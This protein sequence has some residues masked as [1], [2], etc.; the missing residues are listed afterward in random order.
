VKVPADN[1]P[2]LKPGTEWR[3]KTFG[4]AIRSRVMVFEPHRELGWDAH[5]LANHCYHGWLFEALDGG[6][7]T[8][9]VT[10]ESQNG[11]INSLL[12][13]YLRW[14]MP[15]GHQIWLESLKKNAESGPPPSV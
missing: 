14:N 9:V 15:R 11:V 5:S 6:A 4:V 1:G 8:K 7:R 10:E 13:W 2:D 12:R 3:W